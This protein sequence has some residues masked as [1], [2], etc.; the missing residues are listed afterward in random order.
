MSIGPITSKVE[1]KEMKLA[2]MLVESLSAPFD[3]SKYRDTYKEKLDELI[4][5][6]IAGEEVVESRC[7]QGESSHGYSGGARAKSGAG[8]QAGG[9]GRRTHTGCAEETEDKVNC[10]FGRHQVRTTTS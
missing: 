7:A 8:S 3:P 2:L 10:P 9:F 6:K 4:A 1:E 5:A